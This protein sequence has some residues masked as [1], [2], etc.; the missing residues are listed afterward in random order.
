MLDSLAHMHTAAEA[1]DEAATSRCAVQP[2]TQTLT[3]KAHR[4]VYRMH[5]YFARRPHNLFSALVEHYSRPN[6][7]VLDPFMG[8]G[9]TLVEATQLARRA[10]G[11]D[12][13]P[14]ATFVTRTE[15]ARIPIEEF[16]SSVSRVLKRF[17]GEARYLYTSECRTCA[18]TA[19]V[20]WYEHSLEVDCATCGAQFLI[21][22]ASKLGPGAWECIRCHARV[23]AAPSASA[24]TS[25]VRMLIECDVCGPSLVHPSHLDLLRQTALDHSRDGVLA[26]N[27]A[28]I[29]MNAIPD[30]NMQRE[31]ALHKKGFTAFHQFF[32]TRQ[33]IALVALRDAIS[34][35]D[36]RLQDHL[37]LTFSST[38]RFANRMVTRNP[39]WRGDRPLEW[40]GTG[41]WLPTVFLDANLETEFA[42]RAEAVFKGKADFNGPP[43]GRG[44]GSISEVTDGAP[45]A[46]WSAQTRSSTSIPLP[47]D[48]VDLI[49][50]DPP[51]GSYVHYADMSNFWNVWLPYDRELKT[52]IVI[53][54][55]EEAVVARKQFPGAKG[56]DDY[57]RLLQMVFS[58]CHRVLKPGHC[59]VLT[60]NNREPRAWVA[61]VLA[62]VRA[63]FRVIPDGVTFQPG[64]ANYRHTAR[65]RRLGSVHG[66]F[67]FTFVKS[68]EADTEEPFEPRLSPLAEPAILAR[69]ES[70]LLNGPLTPES[71]M[72]RFYSSVVPDLIDFITSSISS[73]EEAGSL[74]SAVDKLALFDSVHRDRLEK[75][76]DYDGTH[77]SARTWSR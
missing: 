10:I 63:G 43:D 8:G 56:P 32:T 71:L 36:P 4:P 70:L 5:R 64:V 65:T 12:T 53:D 24:R 57:R 54:D 46:A 41:F 31:S 23:R 11:F 73:D 19:S 1:S 74:L 39:S 27:A 22:E 55:R 38:L 35:E 67:V 49:L 3:A 59:M 62:A 48:T 20:K 13:S 26:A 61:L 9:V 33:L 47:D 68:L 42:R 75:F 50:T 77:W 21:S 29:P 7:L 25:L 30:N 14:I 58:E 66:D 45:G 51:Y 69:L 16:R 44:E 18:L 34:T 40:V 28:S 17:H 52:G 72:N 2:L 37:L 60:F 76:L 15:L 6:Q